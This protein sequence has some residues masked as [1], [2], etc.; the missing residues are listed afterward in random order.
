[1]A[2]IHSSNY[3]IPDVS[4]CAHLLP[5]NINLSQ[6]SYY[7]NTTPTLHLS[8]IWPLYNSISRPVFSKL[9]NGLWHTMLP[10]ITGSDFL[11][12]YVPRNKRE[13]RDI[14]WAIN[15]LNHCIYENSEGKNMTCVSTFSFQ[16][17]TKAPFIFY[18]HSN[19]V[20]DF[21]I[22]WAQFLKMQ[23]LFCIFVDEQITSKIWILLEYSLFHLLLGDTRLAAAWR[24]QPFLA[25][26]ILQR[27]PFFWQMTWLPGGQVDRFLSAMWCPSDL[28][29]IYLMIKLVLIWERLWSP[30]MCWTRI[31][32]RGGEEDSLYVASPTSSSPERNWCLHP[33][34]SDLNVGD[35]THPYQ[36][37][38]T[39]PPKVT[40]RQRQQTKEED[41]TQILYSLWPLTII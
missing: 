1:M 19:Y 28:H 7:E 6:T 15:Q 3:S 16:N 26:Q 33:A 30:N 17:T 10:R 13:D 27:Y 40:N 29:S 11:P 5:L 21:N 39:H 37:G 4:P 2:W 14:L 23:L 20:H 31:S 38:R 8:K 22:S 18:T 24:P 36:D 32:H 25:F 34:P 12:P 9:I 41:L 35:S